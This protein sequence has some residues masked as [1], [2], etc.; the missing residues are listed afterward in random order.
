MKT[1][2][3]DEDEL[4]EI[5]FKKIGKNV[6]ISR[7]AS[8]YLPEEMEIGNNVRIDDFC[9]LSGKIKIGNY[10]HIAAGCYLFAGNAGI[11]LMDFAGLSSR[12][13][14]YAITE[15]Y[16]GEFLTN[17]TIP[18]K[19]RNVISAP[20]TLEKHVI[21]G[22]GSTI[23]PGVTIGE[24]SAIGAMSLVTKSIGKWKIAFGIPAKEVKERS[25]NLLK[26]EEQ[27]MKEEID[28]LKN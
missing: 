14:I 2:F 27:L 28:I 20:V 1:S 24:G 26:F 3:Y 11:T 25:K 18:I 12:C 5:G 7:K 13:T 17:P 21:V 15:D 9:I 8:I 19:Y 10:V 16:S 6:R 22:T 23:L 4:K